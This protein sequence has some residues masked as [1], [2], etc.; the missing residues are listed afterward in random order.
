VR[1]KSLNLHTISLAN[2]D[3]LLT[4][5]YVFLT[6]K[7]QPVEKPRLYLT[8]TEEVMGLLEALE[9]DDIVVKRDAAEKLR[10]LGKNSNANRATIAA[11]GKCR[12]DS[13]FLGYQVV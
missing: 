4:G 3:L 2:Q 10:A 7:G 9:S 6:A 13:S 11:A 12:L 8:N 5:L 1:D